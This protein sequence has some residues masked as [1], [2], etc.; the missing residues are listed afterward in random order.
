MLTLTL[1]PMQSALFALAIYGT[2]A[3][4]DRRFRCVPWFAGVKAS[5]IG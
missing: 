4:T 3:V 2:K 1:D 5:I